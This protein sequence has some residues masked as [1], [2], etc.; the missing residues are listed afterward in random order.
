MTST[1]SPSPSATWSAVVG[2]TR[3]AGF[4]LGA[5]TGSAVAS[6]S[7]RATGCA[8]SRRPTVSPPALTRR[9]KRASLGARQDQGQRAGPEAR[10]EALGELAPANQ[11]AGRGA[12]GDVD[13]QRVEAGRP[14]AAKIAAT[15]RSSVAIAPRP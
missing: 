2:L 12:V 15:A 9:D 7:A 10:G 3:P 1:R 5:A 6:S 14:L 13:D 4:A 8:G 11:R